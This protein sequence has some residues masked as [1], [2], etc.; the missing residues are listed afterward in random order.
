LLG[1]QPAR[2]PVFAK[3]NMNCRFWAGRALMP[4]E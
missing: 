3:R 1:A 4:V 2:M